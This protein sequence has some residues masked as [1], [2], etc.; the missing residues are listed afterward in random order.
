MKQII[1]SAI[2]IVAFSFCANAQSFNVG[3]HAGL[4]MGDAG[5]AYSF[6]AGADASYLA[7][8]TDELSAGARV[9]YSNY[10]GKTI[11]ADGVEIELSDMG[12]IPVTATGEYLFSENFLGALDLG[13]AVATKKGV[14]GGFY[15]QPKLG[16]AVSENLKALVGYEGIS[17]NGSSINAL[18]LGV[19]FA[20]G[21]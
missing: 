21:Q 15:Y 2:A 12:F 10:F 18:N 14:D 1:L 4:P 7:P 3:V 6:V 19:Q 17:N 11:K 13:Y 5:D 8:V 16:Y 20:I 9:G